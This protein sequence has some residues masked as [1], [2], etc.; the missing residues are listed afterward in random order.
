MPNPKHVELER[1]LLLFREEVTRAL[2]AGLQNFQKH[3]GIEVDFVLVLAIHPDGCRHA[4][5]L[6]TLNPEQGREL[7]LWSLEKATVAAPTGVVN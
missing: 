3:N 5:A 1:E 4:A 7:V 2:Q 6:S